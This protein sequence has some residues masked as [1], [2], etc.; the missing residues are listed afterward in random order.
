ML[1]LD[2]IRTT[3]TFSLQNVDTF[4]ARAIHWA[5]QFE[6]VT[7]L[8]SNNKADHNG[9]EAL[10]AVGST[11]HIKDTEEGAFNA[12]RHFYEQQRDWCFGFLAYDL[13][14]DTEAITSNNLDKINLPDL[15]FFCP[16]VV[17]EVFKDRV[18]IHSTSRAPIAIFRAIIDTIIPTLE[19]LLV[20]ADPYSGSQ[21]RPELRARIPRAEYLQ[22]V[23]DI[24]QHI[25]AG[26]IYELNF[27]QEFYLEKARI[28]PLATFRKLNALTRS[29]FACYYKLRDQY[30][31]CASP[32]RFLRKEGNRLISQPIKGTIHRGNNPTE[33]AQLKTQLF[34]S[35]KDRSENVMIVDLVRNDLGRS[36]LP[37]TVSVDELFGIYTFEQVHQ[38]ISTVSGQIK[39]TVHFIDALKNCFPMGSMTGAPKLRA[40]QLIEK[41]ELSKRGL[42]SGAVGYIRPNGDFD[43]NVVIRSLLYNEAKEYLSFQVGGAIVF[44]SV[45]ELEYEECLLKAKAIL[46]VLNVPIATER[47]A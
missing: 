2:T 37:G 9:Y 36:C 20:F 19:E 14:N 15:H 24:R 35:K 22:K 6:I 27:C 41:Y 7:F 33:D 40:M 11:A 45:A 1:S 31:L 25:I 3:S 32:E 47:L 16:E 43:F 21:K 18:Q 34:N 5:D 12:L 23:E 10:L 38:M 30:L 13:K 8:D 29:P 28:H 39:P 46:E 42:Y 26:D 4:K 17:I 44:D